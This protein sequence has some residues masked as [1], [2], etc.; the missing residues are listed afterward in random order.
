[1]PPEACRSEDDREVS[2]LA[3]Q[4]LRLPGMSLQLG[5]SGSVADG[6]EVSYLYLVPPDDTG[7]WPQGTGGSW[8]NIESSQAL[9]AL[10]HRG[11][12]VLAR[13]RHEVASGNAGFHLVRTEFTATELRKVHEAV[14][15]MDIDQANFNKRVRSWVDAGRLKDLPRKRPTATRPALLFR[16]R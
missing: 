3:F 7:K 14:L 2:R 4:L 11:E 6:F 12:D 1:M 10:A 5:V 15:R 13:L 9:S 8:V 16:L